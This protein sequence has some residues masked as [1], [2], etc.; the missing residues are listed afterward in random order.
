VWPLVPPTARSE[1]YD[2]PEPALLG[3]RRPE[4]DEP[5]PLPL[6]RPD[7][8]PPGCRGGAHVLPLPPSDEL[9][10]LELVPPPLELEPPELPPELDDPPLSPPPRGTACW[11][12]AGSGAARLAVTASVQIRCFIRFSASPVLTRL[13]VARS[14]GVAATPLPQNE[15]TTT[16]RSARATAAV[17]SPVSTESTAGMGK[18]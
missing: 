18:H 2:D 15:C 7:V 14:P 9:D 4:A 3:D 12:D 16:W 5:E 11:P 13:Q 6:E 10:P 17:S 8:E 1:P